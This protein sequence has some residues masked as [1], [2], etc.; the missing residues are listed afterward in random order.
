MTRNIAE[1]SL[2]SV[3]ILLLTN[4]TPM[5]SAETKNMMPANPY[6]VYVGT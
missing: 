2:L 3:F 6:L 4:G 1:L 5:S